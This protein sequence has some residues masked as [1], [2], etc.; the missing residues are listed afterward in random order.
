MFYHKN[1][2]MLNVFFDEFRNK[3]PE[4]KDY[5]KKSNTQFP[6]NSPRNELKKKMIQ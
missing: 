3:Y 6:L 5:L 4:L 1:F 2:F